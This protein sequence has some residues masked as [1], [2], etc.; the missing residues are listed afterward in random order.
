MGMNFNNINFKRIID[1]VMFGLMIILV[2]LVISHI[3]QPIKKT[4][5]V[6]SII[7]WCKLEPHEKIQYKEW[8]AERIHPNTVTI[9]CN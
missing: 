9:T 7:A 1:T 2:S 5:L 8:V 6:S 3:S 4:E